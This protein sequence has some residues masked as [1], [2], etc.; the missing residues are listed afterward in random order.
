MDNKEIE[1]LLK[2][3]ERLARLSQIWIKRW[4]K[5]LILSES[6]LIQKPKGFFT[7]KCPICGKKIKIICS[8][9]KKRPIENFEYYRCNC[10]Y[11][12]SRKI[13]NK[14]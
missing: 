5:I 4:K 12:Y 6:G 10:G 8:W 1:H 13:K 9:S 3:N 2:V 7:K 14:K 11:E